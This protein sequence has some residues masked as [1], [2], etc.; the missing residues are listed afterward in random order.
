M[1][2]GVER[3]GQSVMATQ[4]GVL[5]SEATLEQ[6]LPTHK[7]SGGGRLDTS[8]AS[9]RQQVCPLLSLTAADAICRPGG[10]EACGARRPEQ[11]RRREEGLGAAGLDGEETKCET[12][13]AEGDCLGQR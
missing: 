4:G 7:H 2:L 3:H 12:S 8:C 5:G 10:G 13:T 6:A 11:G 9:W 1:R